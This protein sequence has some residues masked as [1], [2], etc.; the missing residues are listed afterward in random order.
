M[1]LAWGGY[2]SWY[3][4][5]P[6]PEPLDREL[7]AGV[8]YIREKI[9]TPRPVVIHAVIVELE[10]P[11]IGFL[12][13]P[14]NPAGER[15]FRAQTTSRFLAAEGVQVAINANYFG[16][17]SIKSPWDYYPRNGE[18]VDVWGPSASRG[19]LNG[20]GRSEKTVLNIGPDNR[21]E[22]MRWSGGDGGSAGE[23]SLYNAI[24]GY[25]LPIGDGPTSGPLRE[26]E[27]S[28]L[29][30]LS[31]P[32]SLAMRNNTI[33]P[34]TAVA[35]DKER[36]RLILVVVDGRQ[37][38]YSEGVTQEELGQIIRRLGGAEAIQLDGGGSS[39]L[40]IEGPHGR[41]KVLNSP[42]DRGLPGFE[43]PVA[44]HLGVFAK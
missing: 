25:P 37:P 42:I 32:M 10:Q 16:P 28:P 30:E 34:V 36:K 2:W 6:Q 18:P 22:F 43:R 8:H 7:F 3:Y 12:V 1:L 15:M 40:V 9:A 26:I 35:L 19:E 14:G 24:A 33:N 13:T 27:L 44:N 20:T 21:A 4:H 38:N 29:R 31:P 17:H 39:T 41:P 5:R 11:G 23:G